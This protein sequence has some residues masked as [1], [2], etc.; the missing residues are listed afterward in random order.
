[1]QQYRVV[2]DRRHTVKKANIF[3]IMFIYFK[4]I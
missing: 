2:M 1:L 4:E 3:R